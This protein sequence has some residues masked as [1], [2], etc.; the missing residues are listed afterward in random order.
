MRKDKRVSLLADIRRSLEVSGYDEVSRR[1]LSFEMTRPKFSVTL[2]SA[3]GTR[4]VLFSVGIDG[5]VM[6]SCS[7]HNDAGWVEYARRFPHV[8]LAVEAGLSVVDAFVCWTRAGMFRR[9]AAPRDHFVLGGFA[10]GA[11]DL[12]REF[13]PLMTSVLSLR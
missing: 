12:E 8:R 11:V 7:V 5:S 1:L 13:E 9:C 4:V 2:R 6:L 10:V 3:P